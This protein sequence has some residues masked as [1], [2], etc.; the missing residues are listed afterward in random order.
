M[1]CEHLFRAFVTG[2]E[3]EKRLLDSYI[4]QKQKIERL[5]EVRSQT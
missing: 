2:R 3:E 5:E 4:E 1:K